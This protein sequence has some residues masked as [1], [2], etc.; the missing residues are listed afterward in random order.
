MDD[1]V[2]VHALAQA[3]R[4]GVNPFYFMCS[5]NP[6]FLDNSD[7]ERANLPL[8][9]YQ[10]PPTLPFLEIS[11]GLISDL[12]NIYYTGNRRCMLRVKLDGEP[13]VLKLVSLDDRHIPKAVR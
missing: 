5:A 3:Q 11:P 8:E 2:K 12:E 6:F 4:T 13:R 10:V 9:G 7:L 1:Q